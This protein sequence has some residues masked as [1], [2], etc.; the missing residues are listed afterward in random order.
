MTRAFLTRRF[1]PM[2]GVMLAIANTASG[3]RTV[4]R[5]THVAISPD[6]N[7]VAWIGPAAAPSNLEK[8]LFISDLSTTAQPRII[9]IPGVDSES[10]S[11]LAWSADSRHLA[12]LAAANG[13]PAVYVVNGE[14]APAL[15]TTV[16]GA[17]H[18]IRWSP[19]GTRIA[20]LYSS[21]DEVSNNA[22]AAAPRDTG[23]IGS[24]PDR[25][26]LALIDTRTG[27]LRSITPRDIYIYEYDWSPD[28][29]RLVVSQARG[30][31][32][33]NWW[34][35][36]LS[37]LDAATGEMRQLAGPTHQIAN[38]RWSPDGS[39]IAYIGGL[40]S[41][42]SVTGGDLYVL[43]ASGGTPR[44]ITPG[45]KSS[46][47]SFTW[48]G[49][50]TSVATSYAQGNTQV[51]KINMQTGAE[52]VQVSGLE[53]QSVG[54]VHFAAEVSPSR[55]G[56]AI[57]S[58]RESFTS[59]P[60]V[61]ITTRGTS[62]Q[63]THA[64]DAVP[65]GI[66]RGV[67]VKWKSDA[68]NV[69]GFLLY[70]ADF[71]AKKKYPLIVEVH[72]GPSSAFAPVFYA[73]DSYEGLESRAGY[74]VFLPNPRG[75]YGQGEAFTRANVKDF[76]H[77]DLR[78]ILAGLDEIL[79]AY[80]VD[81]TRLGIRGW[82]YGGF[83]TMWAVTQS[84]R[85]KAAVAGAGIANWLSYTGENGISEWMV[86][87]F[88]ATAYDDKQVYE[89]SSPIYFI[90]NART[91][92]LVVVGERD[93]ECPAPQSYEFW[94]G[95]QHVGVPTQLVVYPDEGH[96]FAQPAHIRDVR[97]RTVT[98]MDTYLKSAQ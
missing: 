56:D 96:A 75:S 1:L 47:T 9:E 37:S 78:D 60:E 14:A 59:P 42:Q 29:K 13:S 97:V 33:N 61:W 63:L 24:Q 31:G 92:T 17:L 4:R 57:A 23:V 25:Q 26:H 84:H 19:N 38:P 49:P 86:P 64:N 66:G 69:Q 88:G 87:F 8:A 67:S 76:G 85:F 70:P 34:V 28:A 80:P 65:A 5:Y 22:L 45:I 71:D 89:K 7:R 46:I 10:P 36:K 52:S 82:S 81:G 15:L 16:K 54:T 21:L 58:V 3:Q 91:P 11:Q 94:R 77:G 72:G 51:A 95:L 43:P 50:T 20:G 79:R 55:N 74:F 62:R 41:D 32:N 73:P 53:Q 93:T 68:F 2:L 44:D 35:A 90:R 48:T 12:I 6:G 98:W 30:S 83:M 40:M 27:E 39:T 18:D